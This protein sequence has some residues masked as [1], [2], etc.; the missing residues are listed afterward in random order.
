MTLNWV[1][2]RVAS[3]FLAVGILSSCGLSSNPLD[4]PSF[5]ITGSDAYSTGSMPFVY[6][7]STGAVVAS[8]NTINA[9][10][11]DNATPLE[12]D[13]FTGVYTDQLNT[14]SCSSL[15][16]MVAGASNNVVSTSFSATGCTDQTTVNVFLDTSQ[17]WDQYN[18]DGDV[19]TSFILTV[20]VA[21]KVTL[22]A[23]GNTA[24]DG[25]GTTEA[26]AGIFTL[27]G[28]VD[29]SIVVTFSK[30]L[31]VDT[32][33]PTLT[34]TLSGCAATLGT[35]VLVATSDGIT[36]AWPLGN[37]TAVA[38]GQS[39]TLDV[40]GVT[41]GVNNPEDPTDPNVTMSFTFQ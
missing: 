27:T 33:S 36:V 13:S 11:P 25:S 7:D 2:I 30:N 28:S 12:L 3:I 39:C 37:L 26:S 9:S 40:S 29:S 22:A 15:A 32:L 34:G 16:S 20:D 14:G 4:S 17:V 38:V 31:V 1:W 21:P 10:F 24:A 5:S 35:P 23:T 19:L 41:D 6:A 8:G 18:T